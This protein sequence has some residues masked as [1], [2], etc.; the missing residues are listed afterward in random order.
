MIIIA[1]L[2]TDLDA[3]SSIPAGVL[4]AER[5]ISVRVTKRR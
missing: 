3:I 1:R 2:A 5:S 4:F